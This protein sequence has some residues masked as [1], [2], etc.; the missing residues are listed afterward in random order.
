MAER[1][2]WRSNTGFLLAAIGSAV[3]LG[4]IWRFS[5]LC[6]DNGGG[7]FLLPYCIALLVVG[8]PILIL[9]FAIGHKMR[10]SAP[11]CMDR[12]HPEWQWLGWWSVILVMFGIELYYTVVIAWCGLYMLYSLK[13][14]FPWADDP[15]AFFMNDFLGRSD[16]VFAIEAIQWPILA[17]SSGRMYRPQPPFSMPSGQVSQKT[18]AMPS[19]SQRRSRR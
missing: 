12:V 7:T 18:S 10:A 3:G 14:H 5:Y 13:S 11:Q 16:G 9:E 1:S 6:Y 2:T 4:N 17:M 19:G 15:S 8:A